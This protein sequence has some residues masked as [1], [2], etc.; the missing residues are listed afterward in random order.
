MRA[1][2]TFNV[3]VG[4]LNSFS[5]ALKKNQA[6]PDD[7]IEKLIKDY[8]EN[9]NHGDTDP[10]PDPG[11]EEL[12]EILLSRCER[13]AVGQFVQIIMRKLLESG[14]ADEETIAEMQ[15][16]SGQASIK[17]YHIDFGLYNNE[18]FKTPFPLLITE[19]QKQKYDQPQQFAVNP[20]TIYG[21]K[22]H[23]SSQWFVQNRKSIEKWIIGH[24]PKWFETATEEQ[25]ADME[26]FILSR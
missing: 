19:E 8:V 3:D 15:K 7:V 5:E 23:I 12:T 16:A 13:Y 10:G 2:M 6:F 24:L 9:S 4:L 14:V 11:P 18:N 22:Y 1:Q 25:K 21:K 20:L 26:K 17:K